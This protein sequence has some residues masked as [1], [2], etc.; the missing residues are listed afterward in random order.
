M[1]DRMAEKFGYQ[2]EETPVGF[3]FI[4]ESMRKRGSILGGEESG[5]LSI[6]GHIPEKDGILATLLMAEI[7]AI[8]GKTLTGVIKQ[9]T[10]EFGTVVSERMDVC[11]DPKEKDRIME[12]LRAFD[13]AVFNGRQVTKRIS[14][15]GTKVILD[16]GS[17][18]LIRASGTEPL[19]RIYVEANSEQQMREMQKEVRAFFKM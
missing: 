14:L 10:D 3:K 13:P 4:G 16:D 19:F 9:I 5:G 7:R 15:D 8:H 2:A 18:V 17:W 12:E 1:L 11:V 6:Q